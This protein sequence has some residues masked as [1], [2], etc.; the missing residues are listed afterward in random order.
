MEDS[1]VI[2]KN[3]SV[4]TIELSEI[5]ENEDVMILFSHLK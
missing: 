5:E 2:K 4:Q 1:I 3:T